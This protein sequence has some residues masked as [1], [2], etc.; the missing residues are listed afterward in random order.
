MT[1]S[2]KTNKD[3]LKKNLPDPKELVRELA[4]VQ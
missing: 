2:K 3:E 4:S 1:Q